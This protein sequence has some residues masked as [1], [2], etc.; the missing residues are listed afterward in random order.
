MGMK[1]SLARW[2]YQGSSAGFW[3]VRELPGVVIY[4]L[5][6]RGRWVVHCGLD[7]FNGFG[8]DAERVWGLDFENK[9]RPLPSPLLEGAIYPTRYAA[10]SAL[11]SAFSDASG[12]A[13]SEVLA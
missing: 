11:E 2:D 6:G 1:L 13:L 10:L 5:C 9:A 3:M 7:L 12:S 4:S 8:R